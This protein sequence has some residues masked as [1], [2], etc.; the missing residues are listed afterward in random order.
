MTQRPNTLTESFMQFASDC[1]RAVKPL[2]GPLRW[3]FM[4][5]VLMG[6]GGLLKLREIKPEEKEPKP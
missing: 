4:A 5:P 1:G 3:I 2:L 6:L